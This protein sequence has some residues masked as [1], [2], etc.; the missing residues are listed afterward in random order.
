MQPRPLPR[1]GLREDYG[2]RMRPDRAGRKEFQQCRRLSAMQRV[3]E[4]GRVCRAIGSKR[5][6]GYLQVPSV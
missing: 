6:L 4:A 3:N 5:G 2:H 1:V